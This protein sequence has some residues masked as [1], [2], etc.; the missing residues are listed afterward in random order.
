M[1]VAKNEERV[2]MAKTHVLCTQ[3]PLSEWVTCSNEIA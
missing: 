3:Y 1:F 2:P